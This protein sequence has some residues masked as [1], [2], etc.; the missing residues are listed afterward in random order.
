LNQVVRRCQSYG[1]PIKAVKIDTE[2]AEADILE[3]AADSSLQM[4]SQFVIEY[5]DAFVPGARSRCVARL[6][7]AGFRCTWR[8]ITSQPGV[9][10]IY[11]VNRNAS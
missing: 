6:E 2:G 5:H 10:M 8:P 1:R 9:G 11:A 3:G 4:V 7:D